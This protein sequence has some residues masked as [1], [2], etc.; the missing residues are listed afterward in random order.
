MNGE[1]DGA[2]SLRK[3]LEE[4]SRTFYL[5]IERLPGRLRPAI[6]VAYLLLR[7]SDYIE[8]NESM[9]GP[10]KSR[11]LLLWERVLNGGAEF[12]ELLPMLELPAAP[13]ADALVARHGA[14]VLHGL[15]GLPERCRTPILRHVSD[16]TRGMARWVS[17]GPDFQTEADLDDYMH[18]VAGRVGF[19]LT[20]LFACEYSRIRRR[21]DSLMEV[22]RDFGLGLQTVNVIRGLRSDFERGWIYVPASIVRPLGIPREALF[23]AR[24]QD[25]AMKVV[26]WLA[27]KAERHLVIARSYIKLLPATHHAIRLFC[28][29]PYLFA[30]RTL[31]LSRGDPRVLG[32]GTKL[33]RDEVRRIVR[34][35]SLRG[36]SNRWVDSFAGRLAITPAARS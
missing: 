5:G 3:L 19:L 1:R 29:Y 18:E 32:A 7:V 22:A 16:S 33:S 6:R 15:A 11:L 12:G 28:L 27:T 9:P 4:S 10:Q 34:A 35:A 20:D 26:D 17:R 13:S 36:W 14:N 31:A 2:P 8:D 23:E 25:Q 30:V 21:R 24:Y